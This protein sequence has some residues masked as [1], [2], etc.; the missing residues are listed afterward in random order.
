MTM[1]LTLQMTLSST[2]SELSSI[3]SSLALMHWNKTTTFSTW[4]KPVS[5]NF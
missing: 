5:R 1:T 4:N 2:S 3:P